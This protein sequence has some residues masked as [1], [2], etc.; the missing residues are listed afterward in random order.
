MPEVTIESEDGDVD[1]LL[2]GND[3]HR[4]LQSLNMQWNDHWSGI[5]FT[6]DLGE[7]I[8]CSLLLLLF[9]V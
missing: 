9:K 5:T 2:K 4:P 6:Y 3:L 7:F 8:V 1:V